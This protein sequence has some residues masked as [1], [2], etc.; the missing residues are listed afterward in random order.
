[1]KET[2]FSISSALGIDRLFAFVNRGR[3]VVLVFHGVTAEAPGH[4]CNHEGLH[5]YRPIF[6]CLMAFIASRY[7]TVPLARVVD[8]L[9]GRAALPERAVAITFDDGYRNVLTE[10]GPV[11]KSLGIPATLFVATDFVYRHDMLWTDRLLSALHLTR[12]RH[13]SLATPA[14]V[15]DLP[16]SSDADKIAADRRLLAVCKALPDAERVALLNRI[17]ESLGVDESRLVTAW[18]DHTPIAPDELQRLPE[19]G[20]EVGSHTCSHAIVTRMSAEQ[21]ARELTESKRLIESSTGRACEHFSYP[22]G[23][24]ADFDAQTR[25]HVIDAG[26]RGAVTTIKTAVSESHDPFAI[27]RCT[28]THNRITLSEFASE[29]SGFPRFLRDVKSRVTGR[30]ATPA[31]GSWQAHAGSPLL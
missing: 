8:G 21:A 12:E 24:P 30:P 4:L 13:L 3:P 14:G 29:V 2:I 17:V 28:L 16:L 25:Q 26:Y 15:L 10:A 18:P 1:M 6:E 11:L 27:P 19:F 7:R 9:A 31:G 5:L 20:I 23:G 22:N